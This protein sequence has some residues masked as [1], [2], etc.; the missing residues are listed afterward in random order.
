MPTSRT[1]CRAVKT[2]LTRSLWFVS[3]A[4]RRR[5]VGVGV[6]V[7]VGVGVGVWVGVCVGKG[8]GADTGLCVGKGE[9]KGAR[10][11][12]VRV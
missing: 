9:G 11:M 2:S 7:G 3:G 4:I 12:Y 5:G 8:A 6:Y 1:G 10:K